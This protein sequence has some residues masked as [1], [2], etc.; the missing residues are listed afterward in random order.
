MFSQQAYDSFNDFA[1]VLIIFAS[2]VLGM[3]SLS[4]EFYLR[5][6]KFHPLIPIDLNRYSLCEI[7]LA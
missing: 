1:Q 3:N 7:I 6:I 4:V 5:K 2:V